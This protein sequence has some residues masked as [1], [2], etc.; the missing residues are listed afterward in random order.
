MCFRRLL[1]YSTLQEHI[2]EILNQFEVKEQP[3]WKSIEMLHASFMI[4][5]ISYFK[6]IIRIF[7]EVYICC[8]V[9]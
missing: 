1:E 2:D 9:L 6:V 8:F 5:Y 4:I 7:P 3:G